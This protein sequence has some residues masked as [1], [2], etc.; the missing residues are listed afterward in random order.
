[1]GQMGQLWRESIASE[2][3]AMT[4]F[5][6]WDPQLVDLPA[7]K[8]AVDSKL[9]FKHKT[10]EHGRIVKYK[11]RFVA[12]GFSQRPGEDYRE[13]Y[14]SMAKLV[15]V[16]A[17]VGSSCHLQLERPRVRRGQRIPECPTQ[18]GDLPGTARGCQ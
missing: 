14:S 1:M 16:Q 4:D 11:S 15:T 7:G 12:R 2:M 9:V 10:D 3:Q 6:V 18:G 5:G 13:T 17:V 8:K